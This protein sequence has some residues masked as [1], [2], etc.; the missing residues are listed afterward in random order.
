MTRDCQSPALYDISLSIAVS[1]DLEPMLDIALSSFLKNLSLCACGV[2]FFKVDP[3]GDLFLETKYSVPSGHLMSDHY[4]SAMRFLLSD[5][6][7]ADI[8]SF[9]NRLPLS[10]I[11][12]KGTHIYLYSL[13][14]V[15]VLVLEKKGDPFGKELMYAIQP[16]SVRLA[17]ACAACIRNRELEMVT[18]STRTINKEFLITEKRLF[19]TIDEM[20]RAQEALDSSRKHLALILQSLGEGVIVA[21]KDGMVQMINVKALEY[22]DFMPDETEKIMLQTLFS[23]STKGSL[24]LLELSAPGEV[25]QVPCEMTIVNRW[26]RERQI[27]VIPN[28]L[29]SILDGESETIFLVQDVTREKELDR[30]KNEFISNLS[31]EMRTP[32]NAILGISRILLMKNAQ[33]LNSRQSEGLTLI[34]DSGKR[35]L[36]LINDILDLSKIEAGKMDIINAP[37]SLEALLSNIKSFVDPLSSENVT[38]K[39]DIDSSVPAIV[40]ADENRIRQVLVNL[41]GNSFKFT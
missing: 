28:R 30:M 18:E 12:R 7:D 9:E 33:N 6:K 38:F 8:R 10:M 22:L 36:A 39:V 40:D 29:E 20:K 14:Y 41:L 27:R 4:E 2:L 3:E 23:K 16:L 37:F 31:H 15:G 19:I 35:L 5:E 25:E 26:Q 13:P 17:S 34:Y 24:S 32:M 1:A 11:D 21:D